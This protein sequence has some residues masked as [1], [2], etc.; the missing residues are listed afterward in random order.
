MRDPYTGAMDGS[1]RVLLVSAG[2]S[3]DALVAELERLGV[4]ITP[5]SFSEAEEH[6]ETDPP[7]LVALAGALGAIELANMIDDLDDGPRMVIVAER[8]E[9]AK[10]R[11]LNREVV[12]SLFAMETT[13]KVVGQRIE[14]LARRAARRR[15]H[16]SVDV[17][18]ANK[19]S[20]GLPSAVQVAKDVKRGEPPPHSRPP[21]PP[22]EEPYKSP[23]VAA[24]PEAPAP[25]KSEATIG[26]AGLPAAEKLEKPG[27]EKIALVAPGRAEQGGA[28][29]S[30]AM[31]PPVVPRVERGDKELSATNAAGPDA[32][33]P[34]R[35]TK[36]EAEQSILV[37]DED[38]LE[39]ILPDPPADD[40]PELSMLSMISIAPDAEEA[41]VSHPPTLPPAAKAQAN[42]TSSLKLQA[43]PGEL[44]I[45]DAEHALENLDSVK[46][47]ITQ[48]LV[49][50][51]QKEMGGP[52]KDAEM[53][54][55]RAS[56]ARGSEGA[57]SEIAASQ[58]TDSRGIDSAS[59]EGELIE[60]EPQAKEVSDLAMGQTLAMDQTI[61]FADL[62][63]S[64]G[65]MGNDE[66]TK[67]GG[68]ESDAQVGVRESAASDARAAQRIPADPALAR[69]QEAGLARD[70]VKDQART[71]KGALEAGVGAESRKGGGARVFAGLAV[72]GVLLGGA[73][74]VQGSRHTSSGA[75]P[76][77][78]PSVDKTASSKKVAPADA[79]TVLDK[80]PLE[81]IAAP[82]D[83]ATPEAAPSGAEAT[84]PAQD[85]SAVAQADRGSTQQGVT[86]ENPFKR[87][88]K[89]APTCD[90]VLAGAVPT[91]GPDPVSE[92][93]AVWDKARAAIVG[94]KLEEAHKYMCEAV[95]I[96]PESA[97]VEGLAAHYLNRG[98]FSEALRWANRAETL[99][100][101]QKDVGNLL[102]DVYAMMGDVDKA[103]DTWL[104]LL[105]VGAHETARLAPISK[106]YSVEGGRHLRR[107]DLIRAEIFYRRAV[108]LDKENLSGII[109]LA[110]VYHRMEMPTYARAF[111]DMSLKLS[112]VI[113]E[114]H[115]LLGELA[116]A[117]GNREEAR[118][119]FERA[120]AV[121]PDFFPARRGL[122]QVK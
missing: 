55:D 41:P 64:F 73:Y 17:A 70:L 4:E 39:S 31:R 35:A 79:E 32:A 44:D 37:I 62:Q 11:G 21:A 23:E 30:R 78:G 122:S 87:E 82:K 20:L 107:G 75:A 51:A 58:S 22:K 98:A 49:A 66:P 117:D 29:V 100:P 89:A 102:G 28:P 5:C 110:K 81:D 42:E 52:E 92:A 108:I 93:S 3:P 90:A 88:E 118:A 8:K 16:K 6:L 67:V 34:M 13:E 59:Q 120:L 7:D 43:S 12:V 46:L 119:R 47:E 33:R 61:A 9:L 45:A 101:G 56:G 116:L 24:K 63:A 25:P 68:V 111:C 53:A 109:G 114:V 72:V 48:D 104:R 1:V 113:P 54:S 105:N 65:D 96:N 38:L 99:R 71:A 69:S 60:T 74:L 84:P 50:R 14:S 106:D 76:D 91:G 19:T 115:V 2:A 80:V 18:P 10:L 83:A 26:G 85:E 86:L 94:G 15:D 121:R 97:A 36:E 95:A 103:R 57:D 112:D 77:V 27:P 40:I